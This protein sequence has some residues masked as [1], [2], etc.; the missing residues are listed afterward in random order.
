LSSDLVPAFHVPYLNSAH[1]SQYDPSTTTRT[2]PLP[3]GVRPVP[4]LINVRTPLPNNPMFSFV[5]D[6]YGAAVYIRLTRTFTSNIPWQIK[7]VRVSELGTMYIRGRPLRDPEDG[8]ITF[9]A[10]LNALIIPDGEV[11]LDTGMT[12][13]VI[14]KMPQK[15]T[16]RPVI[17]RN[18]I[19][20]PSF[21]SG[22]LIAGSDHSDGS[23]TNAKTPP[24]VWKLRTGRILSGNP[25]P[26][27]MSTGVFEDGPPTQGYR[28]SV[29]TGYDPAGSGQYCIASYQAPTFSPNVTWSFKAAGTLSLTP[30]TSYDV[31]LYA[32]LLSGLRD[33]SITATFYSATDTLLG[34]STSTPQNFINDTWTK[35]SHNF[36]APA[37]SVKCTITVNFPITTPI[38]GGYDGSSDYIWFSSKALVDVGSRDTYT[39]NSVPSTAPFQAVLSPNSGL[40]GTNAIRLSVRSNTLPSNSYQGLMTIGTNAASN[41]ITAGVKYSVESYAKLEPG[42]SSRTMYLVVS[43]ASSTGAVFNTYTSPTFDMASGVLTK[44]S[45]EFT[46]PQGATT[47]SV[48]AY[49]VPDP[50]SVNPAADVVMVEEELRF[51][52]IDAI[53]PICGTQALE[54]QRTTQLPITLGS[55]Q[56]FHLLTIPTYNTSTQD[57]GLTAGWSGYRIS[58]VIRTTNIP[59][60]GWPVSWETARRM[61]PS[62]TWTNTTPDTTRWIDKYDTRYSYTASARVYVA[63]LDSNGDPIASTLT[64]ITGDGGGPI[65]TQWQE[66]AVDMHP[67]TTAVHGYALFQDAVAGPDGSAG[68]QLS[69][70]V[71]VTTSRDITW[72]FDCMMVQKLPRN[73][74]GIDYIDGSMDTSWA[75]TGIHSNPD[76]SY[77]VSDSWRILWEGDAHNSSSVL[78]P[79]QHWYLCNGPFI[80]SSSRAESVLSCPAIHVVD[81]ITPSFGAWAILSDIDSWTRVARVEKYPII[82]RKSPIPVND[83]RMSKEGELSLITR[84]AEQRDRMINVMASGRVLLFQFSRHSDW[85]TINMYGAVGDVVEEFIGPDKS[86]P[87]RIWRI[88]VQ[89]VERPNIATAIINTW[90]K[91]Y[92]SREWSSWAELVVLRSSWQN[93]VFDIAADPRYVRSDPLS[94]SSGQ[95]LAQATAVRLLG[96]GTGLPRAYSG[97]IVPSSTTSQT[98]LPFPGWS[99]SDKQSYGSGTA[100]RGTAKTLLY[101]SGPSPTGTSKAGP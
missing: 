33:V 41:A 16:E 4:Q 64:L 45:L 78:V 19:P 9:P 97:V 1:L 60:T 37:G 69:T 49:F 5:V 98:R 67:T 38:P 68:T 55:H 86:R 100:S 65:T 57:S 7:V 25:D 51:H 40:V 29:L 26:I 27:P 35:I 63:Q 32:R 46:A 34:S 77:G 56:V 28:R 75:R 91:V 59:T 6:E 76:I 23:L 8:W 93:L 13:C 62:W 17:Q 79:P 22:T 31:T 44:A 80:V 2:Y 18:L 43:V 58:G 88:P 84:T 73:Y 74:Y 11:I 94:Y 30:G 96:S 36:T 50:H 85:G 42:S 92:A 71:V 12:Y 61:D 53:A 48:T 21:Q 3:S 87:E 10:D 39:V 90:N 20:N 24:W 70:P 83:L 99:G 15:V 82:G 101:G 81:P 14:L 89:E 72:A 95:N 54:L 47:A 52:G 66:F